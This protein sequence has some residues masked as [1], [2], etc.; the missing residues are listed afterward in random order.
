MTIWLAHVTTLFAW[1]ANALSFHVPYLEVN[2]SL[3]LPP[4]GNCVG[5]IPDCIWDLVRV[6]LQ[7][8]PD[9][10]FRQAACPLTA[11]GV[12]LPDASSLQ[13]KG[14]AFQSLRYGDQYSV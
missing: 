2:D 3:P 14:K 8:V 1:Q 5:G 9:L 10:G 6:V 4:P 7:L 11:P 12:S 13:W